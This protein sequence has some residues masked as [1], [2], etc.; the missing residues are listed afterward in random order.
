MPRLSA[1]ELYAARIRSGRMGGRPRKPNADEA[2]EAVLRR[3]L[4]K[5]IA[6]LE[7]KIEANDQDSW[8]AAIKLIE[9]GWGRPAEQV[10]VQTETP[11]DALT[12][13]Q[14]RALR[15]KILAEHP[16][17]ARLTLVE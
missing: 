10:E 2:R 1:E 9:Y 8:R 6:V 7:K 5:A 11:V 12:L 4:P 13:E 16:E 14:L 3:L 15:A 17:L